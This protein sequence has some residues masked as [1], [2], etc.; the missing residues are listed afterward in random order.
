MITQW[1]LINPNHIVLM[2]VCTGL[3]SWRINSQIF[4]MG[5]WYKGYYTRLFNFYGH[6]IQ[7]D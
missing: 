5:S 6:I 4:P 3:L 7:I 1:D 2:E